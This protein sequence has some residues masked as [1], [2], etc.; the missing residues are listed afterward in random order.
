MNLHFIGR[1]DAEAE[2]PILW[3]HVAKSQLTGKA[4][5]AGKFKGKWRR[6]WQRMRWFDSITNS[7]DMSLGKLQEI[8]KDRE[9]RY[10][11]V[12]WVTKSRM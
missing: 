12:H 11:A 7:M 6:G 4:P 10:A 9:A 2:P 5:D 1:T 8:V 3:P